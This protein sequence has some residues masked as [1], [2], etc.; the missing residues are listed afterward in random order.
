MNLLKSQSQSQSQLDY[1]SARDGQRLTGKPHNASNTSFVLKNA[2]NRTGCGFFS[3]R[4]K[5]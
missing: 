3:S 5:E 4:I 2:N 1:I